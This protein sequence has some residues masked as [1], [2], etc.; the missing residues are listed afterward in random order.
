MP[1][2][3]IVDTHVHLWDPTHFRMPW[4]D[5][6]PRLNKPYV[7]KEFREHTQGIEIAAMVYMEVD[8]APVYALLEAQWVNNLAKEDPRLQ[9]IVA[10][11]PLEYGERARAFLDALKEVGPRV[12]GIRRLLQSE[13]LEFGIQPDFIRGVQILP[14][15]GYSFD[16]CIRHRQLPSAIELVRQCP[17]TSFI[18]DHIAK[19]DIKAH[20]ME[21]WREQMQ[22]LASFPN[23]VCKIS[24]AA[25]EADLEHWTQEDLAPYINH[26]LD[27][28]GEDR[29]IFG[30]DWPV[31]LGASSY[32]RWVETLDAIT[33]NRSEA[34]R[35]K[36][37]AENARRVYRLPSA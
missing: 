23:I 8:I 26:A 14:E 12:K 18:L 32:R 11:A 19:P 24:G 25:T 7:L 21:P 30:G 13:S 4:L 35:R 29:V 1:D 6:N 33:A 15:Y 16:I 22:Q 37:W 27:A 28:F 3:P 5:N 34:A 2:F 31:V 17:Q 9:G 20:L 36:L 10:Y